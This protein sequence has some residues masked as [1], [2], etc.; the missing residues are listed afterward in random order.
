M[1]SAVWSGQIRTTPP[2]VQWAAA[3]AAELLCLLNR[4]QVRRSIVDEDDVEV[5]AE[6]KR[7][8]VAQ[9]VFAGWVDRAAERQHLLGAVGEDD[10]ALDPGRIVRG[11]VAAAGAKLEPTCRGPSERLDHPVEVELRLF[12]VVRRRRE[13]VKP[14]GQL[15]VHARPVSGQGT[16]ASYSV[17]IWP[18]AFSASYSASETFS[19]SR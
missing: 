19:T 7:Q 11:V 18:P 14:L 13:Q 16:L 6:P 5:P 8:H 3:V 17:A 10:F 9:D 4:S 12:G 2:A 1:F 15:V